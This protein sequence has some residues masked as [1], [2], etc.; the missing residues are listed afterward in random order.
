MKRT[1]L[2][3]QICLIGLFVLLFST[4]AFAADLTLTRIGALETQGKVYNEWW[5]TGTNP[6][7]YGTAEDDAKV[8]VSIDGKESTT[9][10]NGDGDWI[11]PSGNFSAGDFDVVI[12]S[13][14]ESLS[15]ALHLG[16][17]VPS[18]V[19]STSESTSSVPSTG[20]SQLLFILSGVSLAAFGWYLWDRSKVLKS[21]ED[22]V[23]KGLD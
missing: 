22:N 13:E 14:G 9:K 10:A 18:D 5:Y 20:F 16:Q 7:L 21:F 23:T 4:P 12:S 19:G 17:G 6:T 15:F 3:T 11:F 2:L 8:T 1:F